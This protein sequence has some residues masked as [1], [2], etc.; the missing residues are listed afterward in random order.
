MKICYVANIRIP[1]EKAHGVQIMKMCEAFAELGHEVELVV[2]TRKTSISED[3]FIYYGVK[4]NFQITR[5]AVPD[6]VGWGPLGFLFE[7]LVFARAVRKMIVRERPDLIFGRDERVLASCVGL[8]IPMQ[9]E[10]HTG[11][12]N[13]AVRRLVA[14][15]VPIVVISDGLRKFYQSHGV[16]TDRMLVAHDG[17]DLGAFEVSETK[18]VARTRLGLPRDVWI[19]LY[20][21]RLDGWKGV[22]TLLEASNMLP[23]DIRVVIIGGEDHQVRELS[24][25]Y[26]RV[27][28]LGYR[29][30]RELPQ[31]LAAADVLV[32]PNT[33]SDAIS[34]SYT[35]PLK[36]FAYLASGRP[37]IA[38]NLPS[39]CEIVDERSAVLVPPDDAGAVADAIRRVMND[40]GLAQVL[41]E[42]GREKVEVH[43]WMARARSILA[44]AE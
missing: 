12:W 13:A 42:R 44:R 18:E 21:G 26:P 17:V 5:V 24:A 39:I 1:T 25:K 7:T 30:Y 41:A 33:G 38:S 29:P 22:G 9:W 15:R 27:T 23:D 37:V 11:A 8:G 10:S 28:F 35:S 3:S 32:L 16:P 36:L 19:A 40:P 43:S 20:A 4:S 2:T 34:R 31:N 14:A 6:T